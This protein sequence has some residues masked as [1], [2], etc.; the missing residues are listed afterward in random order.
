[1]DSDDGNPQLRKRVRQA[2]DYWL[3]RLE[4]IAEEGKRRGEIHSAIDSA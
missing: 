3:N 1:M 2:L 4:S